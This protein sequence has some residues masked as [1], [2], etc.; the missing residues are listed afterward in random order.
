LRYDP[1]IAAPFKAA[2]AAQGEAGKDVDLWPLYDMIRCPTLVVRG[3]TSD[4]LSRQTVAA[5]GERG[6]CARGVEIPGVGHAPMFMD[7]DQVAVVRNF[8]LAA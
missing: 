7:D 8:L 4:L 5:M 1:G 3:E 2:V 6:P